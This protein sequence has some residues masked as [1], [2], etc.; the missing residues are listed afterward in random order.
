M[1][2]RLADNE[3][4]VLCKLLMGTLSLYASVTHNLIDDK[5]V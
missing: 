1:M 5:R 3:S 2:A 4:A